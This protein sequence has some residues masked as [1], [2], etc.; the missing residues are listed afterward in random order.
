MNLT[1]MARLIYLQALLDELALALL[2][3][4]QS[5]NEWR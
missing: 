1:A 5:R 4:R 2:R 3:F